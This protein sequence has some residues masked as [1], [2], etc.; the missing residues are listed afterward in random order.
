MIIKKDNNK[1][2]VHILNNNIDIINIYDVEEITLF[3]KKVLNKVKNKYNIKGLCNIYVYLDN[4]YGMVIEIDNYNKC[5]N[6][7]NV[8]VKFILDASFMIEINDIDNNKYE[9]I[10]YYMGKYYT[11]Y[12][13][14]S[15]SEIIYN[16]YFD[17][18]DKGL[19]IK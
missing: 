12:N 16:N 2:I 1:Y 17:I 15:D 9:D 3:F 13:D 5:T 11:Y 14:T 18:I 19:K 7:L 4:N 6:I 10:Y 8:K